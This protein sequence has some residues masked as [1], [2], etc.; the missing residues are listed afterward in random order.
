MYRNQKITVSLRYYMAVCNPKNT[1]T[2]KQIS[3]IS[4]PFF[5]RNI[6]LLDIYLYFCN[7]KRI[8]H[9]YHGETT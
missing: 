5:I 2:M 8:H 4:V 9:E 1:V 6:S 7:A 3:I